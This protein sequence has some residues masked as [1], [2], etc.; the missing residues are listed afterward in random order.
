[1]DEQTI[2]SIKKNPVQSPSDGKE[3]QEA[4]YEEENK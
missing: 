4:K 3:V 1:M 2:L